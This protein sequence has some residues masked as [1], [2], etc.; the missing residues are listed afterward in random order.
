M[1]GKVR[2]PIDPEGEEVLAR[3]HGSYDMT[4][5]TQ[6]GSAQAGRIEPGFADRFAVIGPPAHCLARLEA[7][8]GLGIDRLIVV[9]PSADADRGEA[10]RARQAFVAEVLPSLQ[11]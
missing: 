9:G 10:K 5:H 8:I 11:A 7:L 4:H 3:V 6:S 1:D 2:T